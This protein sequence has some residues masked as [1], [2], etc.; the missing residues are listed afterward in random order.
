MGLNSLEAIKWI[1]SCLKRYVNN[2]LER[3]HS[4]APF[5]MSSEQ[6]GQLYELMH[7]TKEL[8][9]PVE[10]LVEEAEADEKKNT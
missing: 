6:I 8:W 2:R 9:K 7:A 4:H 3:F 1:L 10:T 5:Q